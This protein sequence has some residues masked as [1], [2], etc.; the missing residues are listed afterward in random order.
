MPLNLSAIMAGVFLILTGAL[1]ATA[2][3]DND[4]VALV[5][6]NG[7]YQHLPALPNPLNDARDMA[8]TL[9][10]AGFETIE[11]IDANREEMLAAIAA[12]AK[13]LG[14]GTDAVFYYAG[15]GVQ[16]DGANFLLP[17][18]TAVEHA[19]DVSRYGID[20]N[21]IAGLMGAGN[22]RMNV[23][24]LDACRDNP[25][26]DMAD[27]PNLITE[28]REIDESL[29][30]A[31]ANTEVVVRS[32]ASG[33]APLQTNRA[34]TIVGY[35]TGPGE[36][37]LDGDGENS[38]YTEALLEH[39]NTPGLEIDIMFRRVRASVREITDGFQV[40]WVASTLEN[41]FYI[42]PI[43]ET[44]VVGLDE[45]MD[46]RIE[47]TRK[48][49]L[50]A[51]DRLIDEAF[52]RIVR[53]SDV[54]DD[55]GAY[56][57]RYPNG[58]FADEAERRIAEL[59]TNPQA[60][61]APTPAGEAIEA[62]L[63]VGPVSAPID[64]QVLA[65]RG[66]APA[67]EVTSAPTSG[68]F[69]RPD[70]TPIGKGH[71][72]SSED[73]RGLTFLPRVG[74]K[75]VGVPED[76]EMKPLTTADPGE[77]LRVTVS[78]ELHPCDTLAGFRY[79]PDRVWDGVQASVL[80]VD[81][82][83]AIEACE[84]AIADYPDVN[85]FRSM[86][87]RAYRIDGR[88]DDAV[89]IANELIERGYPSGYV[90]LGTYYMNGWGVE[91]DYERALELLQ[92]GDQHDLPAAPLRIGEL[93]EAGW[94]VPQDFAEAERWFERARDLGNAYG[95]TRMAR[96]YLRGDGM[97]ADPERAIELFTEAADAGELSA[98][99]TLARLYREGDVVPQDLEES[100]R[101]ARAAAGTG[102][103]SGESALG[104][105][106]ETLP[107]P[108]RDL[109][110]AAFWLGEAD[111]KGDPWAPIYLGQLYLDDEWSGR[112][113][114]VARTYFVKAVERGNTDAAR[115][116]AKLY[117]GGGLDD[118]ARSLRWHQTAA[119]AG[120]IWS[121]RD[122][123]R[124]LLRGEDIEQDVA[125]G[126]AWLERASVGG[127]PWAQRDLGRAYFRG[128]G[129]EADPS[130]AARYLALATTSDDA[131]A[132]AAAN[133]LLDRVDPVDRVR[134]TQSLLTELG[135]DAG[136]P[137]GIAGPATTSALAAASLALG[138]SS[139][140]PAAADTLGAL[141]RALND[142]K[143]STDAVSVEEAGD[144]TLTVE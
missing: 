80:R 16:S 50:A 103:P 54:I 48:L 37:A 124:A 122:L 95:T 29:V 143:Q 75:V 87:G 109:N 63:G 56:L 12:F 21:E 78:S 108:E 137:D 92:I 97:P 52:W 14:E 68:T 55:Y 58:V 31:N 141:A 86:L 74:T 111:A 116:L 6:G 64:D 59:E 140:D 65:T 44:T 127:N 106:Y 142:P 39:I 27:E 2:Q 25:F 130:L 100:L 136:S 81:P 112:Q 77:A 82:G 33:L 90:G 35:S 19:G 83:P 144:E 34:E 57:E 22:A 98:Q 120:N 53:A 110:A 60:V 85:R 96:L 66:A 10:Q 101:W 24:I 20:A 76:L 26:L 46:E 61:P 123:G 117:D 102:M 18:D 40:P 17:I 7:E 1:P 134:A 43:V 114:D 79:A 72:L 139:N 128:D 104:R 32:T 99:V 62:Y 135:F 73:L 84:Q 133:D 23:I 91:I 131:D 4:R 125:A 8:A 93:Y 36:V 89:Q 45:A 47:D 118:P 42:R 67:F 51:P 105:Y 126:L 94:G 30:I 138:L 121:M 129:V 11:V 71:L 113:P 115:N 49:G 9:W 70:E 41:E 15:H 107:E 69:F 38:P 3:K 5:I 13:R 28:L 132:A 119:E 88:L